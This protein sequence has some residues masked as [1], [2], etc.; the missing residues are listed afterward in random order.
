[1]L[2]DRYRP[3]CGG[4]ACVFPGAKHTTPVIEPDTGGTV[5]IRPYLHFRVVHRAIGISVLEHDD[6]EPCP[7][8]IHEVADC[9]F[10]GVATINDVGN[11]NYSPGEPVCQAVLVLDLL[12][13][14]HLVA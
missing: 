13:Q 2:T 4:C 3:V 10:K 12:E 14:G 1:M 8:R 6:I 7:C 11:L 5:P 9:R